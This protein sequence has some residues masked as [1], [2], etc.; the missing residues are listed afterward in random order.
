VLRSSV[1]PLLRRSWRALSPLPGG[2]WLFSRLLGLYAPYTGTLGAM[3][4]R[5]EPGHCVISLRERHKLRNHLRCIHAIAL[6]NLGEMATGLALLNGLPENTR[7]ILTGLEV[8][9]RKK[10]RGRLTAECSCLIPETGGEYVLSGEIRDS[11]GE[12][13]AVVTARWLTG[14]VTG[15]VR[16]D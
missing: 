12:T 7:A 2:G 10:A 11:T 13:V 3:V 4:Q 1:G 16:A 9:Y 14:P 5:L 15:P 8:S 6:G